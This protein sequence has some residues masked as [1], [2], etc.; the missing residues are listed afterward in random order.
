MPLIYT[1]LLI[2]NFFGLFY[3]CIFAIGYVAYTFIVK[4]KFRFYI[5]TTSCM[6]L[7]IFLQP[8][9]VSTM[10]SL[11]S[12]RQIGEDFFI[13]NNVSVECYTEQYNS[14]TY[15]LVVPFL[16]LW[17]LGFP[18]IMFALLFMRR[19]ELEKIEVKNKFGFLYGEYNQST[20]YWEFVKIY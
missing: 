11:I 13:L 18:V 9:L 17:I 7:I 1:S 8:D 20:F 16:L 6:Y 12:C 3:L 4:F 15:G 19:T 10:I 2:S 5:I 14:Y